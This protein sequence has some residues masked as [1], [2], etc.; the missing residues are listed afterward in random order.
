M[1]EKFKIDRKIFK[2]LDLSIIALSILIV[3]FGSIN[4]YSATAKKTGV[5][6]Y[7]FKL[8]IAWLIL[9]LIVLYIILLIDYNILANYAVIIYWGGVLLLLYNNFF[10]S[11]VNGAQ[12]WISFGSRALQ[13]AEFAKL[14]MIIM[15]AKRLDDM[16]G[17][18]N[19]F[20]NFMILTFYAL[21]PMILIV[22]QPD[23]GMTMVCF[24]IVLG[25]F[26]IAGLN[27]KVILGGLA[28]LISSIAL[29]W[30]SSLMQE[31]W[32]KRLTTFLNPEADE[33]GYGL[34]II[35]SKI[36]IGSGNII[37][38]GLKFGQDSGTSFVAQF[39]PEAYTDFIFA[40][41][42][43]KWGFVGALLLLTLYSILIYRFIL[44]ARRAKDIFGMVICIGVVSSFLFSIIQNIGMTIGIMPVT[45]I[46]LPLMSYGGS[47]ML[48]NF[49]AIGLILNVGMRRKKINF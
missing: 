48:T 19:N 29:V 34:Q 5:G 32:K 35:Q 12:G 25:I 1:L 3:I 49:M 26:F 39:V 28:A 6:L 18:I 40:M 10:G 30:N 42:G 27:I 4:I 7:Y 41:V 21:I 38:Q 31:Y 22:I 46:T 20:K 36:G 17:N 2:K 43:E 16:E 13:P 9:G 15:L 24:F 33:L 11:V 14:G 47:S 37:G 8:Q 44:I 23:M 45:G